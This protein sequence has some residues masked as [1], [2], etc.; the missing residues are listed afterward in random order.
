AVGRHLP[1]DDL[2]RG[3]VDD[4]GRGGQVD[5]HGQHR[6]FAD[7]DA[8]GHLGPGADE[9]VVLDDRRIGLQRLEH[10]ADA[11]P[12]GAVHILAD[13]GAGADRGPGVDHGPV[14]DIGADVHETGHQHHVLADIAAAPRHSAG[15]RAEAGLAET[16]LVPAGPLG[17]H[18]VPPGPGRDVDH[19][20]AA[21]DVLAHDPVVVQAK[22]QQHGLLEPLLGL[23][24]ALAVALGDPETAGI[25]KI[26]GRVDRL[27]DLAARPGAQ[28]VTDFPGGLDVGLDGGEVG[29][30]SSLVRAVLRKAG[31]RSALWSTNGAVD[32][33]ACGPTSTV[34]MP[35]TAAGA[36]F[37]SVSSKKAAARA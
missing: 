31:S 12:A 19:A 27:A 9:A 26:D 13:L 23:P 10:P 25:Q 8:F 7:D 11:G 21:A 20:E 29:H 18:L 24:H 16:R 28:G 30:G 34:V 32:N 6:A 37:F 14:V 1:A 22:R 35:S 2:A 5:A 15:D 17:R 4:L 33:G 36:R 3:A